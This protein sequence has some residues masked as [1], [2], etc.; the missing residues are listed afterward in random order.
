MSFYFLFLISFVCDSFLLNRGLALPTLRM[1]LE[2]FT[3]TDGEAMTKISSYCS[4]LVVLSI[5][6]NHSELIEFV[7][8]DL[9]SSII[10][11]LALE[12]NAIISAD[13]VGLCR[14]IFV[15]LCDRHPAPRQVSCFYSS[16]IWHLVYPCREDDT[17]TLL[18]SNMF[19][20]SFLGFAVSAL[21]YPS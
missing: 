5:V 9:F 6:S 1:C 2:A 10:Q 8:R 15:Y 4:V 17:R 18:L 14:E 13:L 21:Y 11:G 12:S 16:C 3:W 7:S 19:S 20:H